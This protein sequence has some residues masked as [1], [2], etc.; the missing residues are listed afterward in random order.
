MKSRRFRHRFIGHTTWCIEPEL[1]VSHIHILTNDTHPHD[2]CF[3]YIIC[4]VRCS[5]TCFRADVGILSGTVSLC[6]DALDYASRL[7]IVYVTWLFFMRVFFRGSGDCSG[8]ARLG[9]AHRVF[10]SPAR[11]QELLT[12]MAVA[13]TAPKEAKDFTFRLPAPVA[14][15]LGDPQYL[16]EI[17]TCLV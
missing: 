13:A 4:R 14:V 15:F 7:G 9:Y 12:P 10:P 2:L 3:A 1:T 5:G 8:N 11:W 17:S 16:E 6:S